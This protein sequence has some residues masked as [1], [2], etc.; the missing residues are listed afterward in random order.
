MNA[1]LL[2]LDGV[3]IRE[4]TDEEIADLVGMSGSKGELFHYS[5]HNGPRS[6]IDGGRIPCDGQQLSQLMY[7]DVYADVMAGKQYSI[8]EAT[9]QAA[10][11]DRAKWSTGGTGW[12]RVPDLNG[13]QLGS[14][15]AFYLRGSPAALGGQGVGDA[16]RDITGS[17]PAQIGNNGASLFAS[18]GTGAVGTGA[19]R[20][21]L[22]AVAQI[23]QNVPSN[24]AYGVIGTDFAA[25]NTVPTADENRTKSAYGVWTVRVATGVTNVGSV[26]VLQLATRVDVITQ[27]LAQATSAYVY[28]GGTEAAPVN[29]AV[30]SHIRAA[31]PFP[32]K[33][34]AVRLELKYGGEWMEPGSYSNNTAAVGAYGRHKYPTDEVFAIGAVN[35]LMPRPNLGCN[36]G[37]NSVDVT[38]P[39][40]VRL[41]VWIV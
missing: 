7:P 40:P 22:G 11:L 9:W 37:T 10:S 6:S 20:L 12:V 29:L 4:L 32:G 3:S 39:T 26:D 18:G 38:A 41:L 36:L 27:E 24:I 5:W 35:G 8:D 28:F 34:V 1:R 23:V 19:T 13:V 15:K 14:N 21:R 25:S 30:N 2:G 31:N 33:R 17:T 16:I